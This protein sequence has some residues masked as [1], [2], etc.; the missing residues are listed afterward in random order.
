MGTIRDVY[1]GHFWARNNR[2]SLVFS[3]YRLTG[4]GEIFTV[5]LVAALFVTLLN[6]AVPAL[7]PLQLFLRPAPE[8]RIRPEECLAALFLLALPAVTAVALT[9][10]H[11]GL[12]MRYVVPTILGVSIGAAF[13]VTE[14]GSGIATIVLTVLLVNYG[15]TTLMRGLY[16]FRGQ[17]R[18][19][20]AN[21]VVPQVEHMLAGVSPDLPL[22]VSSGVDYMQLAYYSPSLRSRMLTIVDPAGAVQAINTDSVDR[23]EPI[24]ARYLPLNVLDY[25]TFRASHRRF[26][27]FSSSTP[28]DW[29][30]E[31]FI[32]EGHVL[33]LRAQQGASRL[34]EVDLGP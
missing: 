4:A 11:G 18:A 6:R 22:V 23:E 16:V 10:T 15:F 1:G 29:W 21:S 7:R 20:I 3:Y 32:R 26:L 28:Y 25:R 14:M 8:H 12:V 5:G 13:A 34:Y 24:L 9:L 27:L 31:R 2:V 17:S 33:T 30:P 19:P